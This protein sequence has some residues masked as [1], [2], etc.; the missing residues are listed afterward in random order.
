MIFFDLTMSVRCPV[1]SLIW[2]HLR[3]A[4][5]LAYEAMGVQGRSI[6]VGRCESGI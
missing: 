2:S 6:T 4:F 3:R 5:S 1:H